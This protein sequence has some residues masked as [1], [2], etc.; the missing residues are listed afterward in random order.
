MP[1]IVINSL[2]WAIELAIVILWWGKQSTAYF[3]PAAQST[4]QA[5]GQGQPGPWIY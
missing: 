2:G 1:T 5:P 3:R 4:P